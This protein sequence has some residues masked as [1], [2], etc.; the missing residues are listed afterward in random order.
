MTSIALSLIR[1]AKP[2]GYGHRAIAGNQRRDDL[3]IPPVNR[4][5]DVAGHILATADMTTGSDMEIRRAGKQ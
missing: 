3:A 1:D 4:R 2:P 5:Q